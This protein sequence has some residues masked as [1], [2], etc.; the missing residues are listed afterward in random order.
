M[1]VW[2]LVDVLRIGAE[3]LLTLRLDP[4]R[5]IPC[6]DENLLAEARRYAQLSPGVGL[7]ALEVAARQWLDT[8]AETPDAD[9]EHPQYGTLST[10]DLI[11]R[12][13]HEVQHH[14]GDI[15]SSE[16]GEASHGPRREQQ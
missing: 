14:L 12:N 16:S 2:H 7:A 9:I 1:Y 13:A 10:A 5:G 4:T 11:R 3:R 8:V 6:W 15:R